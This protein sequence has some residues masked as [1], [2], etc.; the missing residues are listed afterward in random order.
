LDP[1]SGRPARGRLGERLGLVTPAAAGPLVV[2]ARCQSVRIDGAWHRTRWVASRP[3]L[4]L[5]PA[6]LAPFVSAEG[7]TRTMTVA[8]VPVS[9]SGPGAGSSAIGTSWSRTRPRRRRADG[10]RGTHNRQRARR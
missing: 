9:P 5:G 4:P 10:L 2:E 8:M 1:T 7:V 3:R 6:W